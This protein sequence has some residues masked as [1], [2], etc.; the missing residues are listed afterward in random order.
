MYEYYL[1]VIKQLRSN[2]TLNPLGPKDCN[3]NIHQASCWLKV[4]TL[5]DP[6]QCF[7]YFS[8]PQ[9]LIPTGFLL[10]KSL[11]CFDS[12]WFFYPM[13]I[14]PIYCNWHGHCIQ[15]TTPSVLHVIISLVWYSLFVTDWDFFLLKLPIVLVHPA[16]P[17]HP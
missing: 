3:S 8:M 1:S 10:W 17:P 12:W 9:K 5:P 14:L 4:L 2:S 11:K 15:Y 6:L 16:Q 13:V 7:Q